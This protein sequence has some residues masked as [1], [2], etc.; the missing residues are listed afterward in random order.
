MIDFTLQKVMQ[1]VHATGM[2]NIDANKQ[3]DGVTIDSR[4]VD[5]NNLFIPLVGQRVNG[6]DF[7][8][9]T[10]QSGAVASLW[11]N[12]QAN[13]PKDVPLIFVEHTLDALQQL[14]KA[15]R[16]ELEATFIGITGSSGKTSTKDIVASVCAVG[17]QTQ[18]TFGNRNNE[19]GLPLTILQIR[20]STQV[21]VIEMGIS[22]FHEMDLLT[23]IV[24]PHVAIITSISESHIDNFHEM[25]HTVEE[26]CKITKCLQ[27]NGLFIYNADTPLLADYV[28]N[29]P[30]EQMSIAYGKKD[31]PAKITG[32]RIHTGG[33]YF[34]T[35]LFDGYEFYLP[36]LGEHQI[37]NAMSAIVCAV[38]LGLE[39][40]EIQEGFRHIDLTGKRNE[41]K[42]IR[43]SIVIDDTYNANPLSMVAALDTL[44]NYPLNI[45]KI[46]VLGDMFGLG[47]QAVELHRRIGREYH[48]KNI[49]ELWV[50]GEYCA[51]LADEVKVRNLPILIRQFTEK[52]DLYRALKEQTNSMSLILVKASRGMLLDELVTKL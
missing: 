3:I 48:F 14:A 25:I 35:N 26:K 39:A 2:Q 29:H 10:I 23:E 30:I 28:K 4:N 16:E 40:D 13:P 45:K 27:P 51:L 32:Y 5:P 1:V 50:I 6:H 43:E 9:R 47:E 31:V 46:A 38:A 17:Y 49:Q 15:Y 36:M 44:S 52:E 19:I 8:I 7:V 11:E 42:K 41:V 34:T 22:D 21:A 33:L 24:K 20:R 18:K 12:G 37:Y